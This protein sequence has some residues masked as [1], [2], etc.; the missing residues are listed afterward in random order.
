MPAAGGL[1]AE[2]IATG[3]DDVARPM[4]PTGAISCIYIDH[5]YKT[6]YANT[7]ELLQVTMWTGGTDKK[8]WPTFGWERGTEEFEQA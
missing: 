7:G 6:R 2:T 8:A 5:N 4:S 3:Y 1:P